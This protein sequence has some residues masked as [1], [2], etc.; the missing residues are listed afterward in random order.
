MPHLSLNLYRRHHVAL[1][2]IPPAAA[3]LVIGYMGVPYQNVDMTSHL[4]YLTVRN[5]RGQELLDAGG[6]GARAAVAWRRRC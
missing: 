5:E 6:W 3:D 4:Q 1:L 2:P